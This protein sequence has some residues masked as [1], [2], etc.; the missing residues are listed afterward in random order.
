MDNT[1]VDIHVKD[2]S[3]SAQKII[4]KTMHATDIPCQLVM[5]TVAEVHYRTAQDYRRQSMP[6]ILEPKQW[7][8]CPKAVATKRDRDIRTVYV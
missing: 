5:L 6:L 8:N 3:K 1:A 2:R 7:H 4:D